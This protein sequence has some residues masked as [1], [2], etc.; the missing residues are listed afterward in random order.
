LLAAVQYFTRLPVPGWVGHGQTL[1]DDAVRYFPAAGVL[2]GGIGALAL[3]A[4]QLLWSESVALVVS[5]VATIVVTGALHED[6]LADTVDGLG[7][8]LTAARALKIMKDSRIGAFGAI[9]LVLALLL[10][11]EALVSVPAGTAAVLLVAGHAASRAAAVLVMTGMTY[12]REVDQSRSTPLIQ[13][14]SAVSVVIAIGTSVAAAIPS[15]PRALI[16]LGAIAVFVVCWRWFLR[17]RLGGYTGDCLGAA[18]QIAECC[19]YLA[20]TSRL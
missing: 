1:L 4:V 3:M 13:N 17:R 10:K 2:V 18:Q 6:G 5:M 19:F 14:V 9:A 15:G 11:Y 8:G 20:C 16:G 7:G 12:V